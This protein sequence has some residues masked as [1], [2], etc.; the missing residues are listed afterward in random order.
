MIHLYTS[1]TQEKI[2]YF[3]YSAIRIIVS[4][5]SLIGT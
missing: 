5:L 4:E 3:N 2:H 1:S